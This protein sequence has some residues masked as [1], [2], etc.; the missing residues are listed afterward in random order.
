M[1][2]IRESKNEWIIAAQRE[3]K[4]ES[5]YTQLVGKFG[6]REDKEGLVRCKG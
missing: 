6:L 4:Q 3:L 1:E 5:N 2:E